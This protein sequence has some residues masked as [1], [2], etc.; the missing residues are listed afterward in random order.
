MVRTADKDK[1]SKPA[2][3]KHSGGSKKASSYNVFMKKEMARLKETEPD[4]PH[5]DR[6][7]RAAQAW[8]NSK[9]NPK[10]KK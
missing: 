3:K 5:R 8:H 7:K 1:A 4:M 9:E 2:A 6:F 10:N